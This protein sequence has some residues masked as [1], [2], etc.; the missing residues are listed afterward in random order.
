MKIVKGPLWLGQIAKVDDKFSSA[1]V[2][3]GMKQSPQLWG[4]SLLVIFG[5]VFA[6]GAMSTAGSLLTS[7]VGAVVVT[8]IYAAVLMGIGY[9]L[10]DGTVSSSSMSKRA[11]LGNSQCGPGT[12]YCPRANGGAGGC[13]PTAPRAAWTQ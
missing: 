7:A 9:A 6:G 2:W 13:V 8:A 11:T 4:V 12:F 3:A 5:L 10:S 1:A